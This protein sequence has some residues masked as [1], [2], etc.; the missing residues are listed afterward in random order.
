MASLLKQ[1][2]RGLRRRSGALLQSAVQS[3]PGWLNSRFAPLLCYTDMLFID[4]GIARIAYNNRHRITE[5]V[6]RSAQ[7]APHHVGWMARRGIKTIV[8]LRGEQSFGTR[9]LE[10]RACARH[11]V[12]LVN[13]ELKS[14]APPTRAKLLAIR[15]L[16]GR[17][18]YPILVHCKSGADRAGLMSAIVRHERDGVPI[19]EAKK[20]L[21]LRFGHVGSADTGVLDAVFQRY[22]E[23]KAKTGIEF[24]DWVETVYDPDQVSKS[25]KARGWANRLV[26]GLL[27]RE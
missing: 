22:L 16:L 1:A 4:Y 5:D 24:W 13:L 10:E 17:V 25:F 7:P 20:Q 3:S 27:R 9:W 23:D 11:G 12:T 21:S 8:N 15:K 19:E 18:E 14:R 26:N 2:K 6:W